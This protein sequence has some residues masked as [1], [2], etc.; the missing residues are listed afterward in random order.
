VDLVEAEI[1]PLWVG[2]T[3]KEVTILS[4]I[5]VVAISRGGQTFLPTLGTVFQAG[6]SIHFAI[7]AASADQLKALLGLT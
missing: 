5:H 1:P 2:R 6:D 3:V 4:E 7:L